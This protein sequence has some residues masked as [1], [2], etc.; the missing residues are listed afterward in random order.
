MRRQRLGEAYG[1]PLSFLRKEFPADYTFAHRTWDARAIDGEL[2]VRKRAVF[3]GSSVSPARDFQEWICRH[4]ST[5]AEEILPD[6]HH[7][8]RLGGHHDISGAVTHGA[9]SCRMCDTDF[10]VRME[11]DSDENR[12]YVVTVYT[13]LGNCEF[14]PCEGWMGATFPW[15]LLGRERRSRAVAMKHSPGAIQRLW[16]HPSAEAPDGTPAAWAWESDTAG[17]E[18]SS[19]SYDS[20]ALALEMTDEF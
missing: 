9:Y 8:P 16:D 17:S 12:T 10:I 6:M 11:G 14:P 13:L 5:L 3:P 20:E 4:M 15:A 7:L 1:P 19:A 18:G 2:V